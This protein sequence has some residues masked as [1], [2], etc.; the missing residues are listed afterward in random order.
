MKHTSL[1]ADHLAMGAK[2][3]PFAGWDMPLQYSGVK[4]EVLAVRQ[5]AGM[6]DVS[7]MGEFWVKGPEAVRFVDQLI[8]NDFMNAAIGKAVYSPL[9][10]EDGSVIDD[11]IAYKLGAEEVL[12]CVNASN[13]EKDWNWIE[14]KSNGF[15]IDLT[16]HSEQTSLIAV[17]G[18]KASEILKELNFDTAIETYATVRSDSAFGQT[19]IARTGYTGEDG[20]EVFCDHE[21]AT[22]LWRALSGLNVVACGLAARDV[23]RLEACYPLYGHELSDEWTPLDAGLKWTVK[24]DKPDFI[25]KAALASYK[26]RWR[27][28]KLVLERGIPRDGYGIK[29]SNGDIIGKVTSG[30]M[31]VVLGKGVALAMVDLAN[32]PKSGE[33]VSVVIRNQDYPA[34]VVKDAFLKGGRA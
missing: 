10:R 15:K 29:N 6:F 7:H 23:L 34:L 17:Q 20:F 31:S 22:Q 16:D 11:L 25:G 13:I 33:T 28:V 3:G 18:P 26:P 4:Q 19:I 30:S 12:I 21:Q 32:A 8:T 14:S 5:S 24:L 9:C 1:H 27:L 2:M